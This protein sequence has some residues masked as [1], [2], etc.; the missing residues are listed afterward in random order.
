MFWELTSSVHTWWLAM[1]TTTGV[2][3]RGVR[4]LIILTIWE[5]WKERNTRI[6]DRRETP[7]PAIISKIKDEATMWSLAGAKHLGL[8]VNI[9]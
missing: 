3:R 8:L 4:L 6:F 2:P 7:A 5:I 9:V 1:A